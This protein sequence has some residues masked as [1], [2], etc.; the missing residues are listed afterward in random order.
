MADILRITAADLVVHGVLKLAWNDGD[1]GIVDLRN[2]IADGDIF[3]HTRSLENFKKVRV[4]SHGQSIYWGEEGQEKVN[5][6]SDRLRK[7]ANEQREGIRN[8]TDFDEHGAPVYQTPVVIVDFWNLLTTG[9]LAPPVIVLG[10][11]EPD[12]VRAVLG[13]RPDRDTDEYAPSAARWLQYGD[14]G[15]SFND[16]NVLQG[17]SYGQNDGE[18]ITWAVKQAV[19]RCSTFG[20]PLGRHDIWIGNNNL[21]VIRLTGSPGSEFAALPYF[22]NRI[23]AGVSVRY[24]GM[25]MRKSIRM[26]TTN[27]SRRMDAEFILKAFKFDYGEPFF[28][29]YCLHSLGV[30]DEALVTDPR[31]TGTIDGSTKE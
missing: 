16:N 27:G 2:L 3:E 6:E 17:V 7:I 20:E 28:I 5:F 21:G 11:T 1:K 13:V 10:Q 25:P 26:I 4:A 29:D 31:F 30:L 19:A 23:P 12:D 8:C 9:A 24:V 18:R 22:V 14:L 15:F